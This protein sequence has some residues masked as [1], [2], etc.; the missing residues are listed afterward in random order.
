MKYRSI[1]FL[2]HEETDHDDGLITDEA[3][4]ILHHKSRDPETED[5]SSVLWEMPTA[6]SVQ[7]ALDYLLQWD[8]EPESMEVYDHSPA[9]F[10]D[11][12]ERVERDGRVFEMSYNVGLS[13]IGLCELIEEEENGQG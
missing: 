11:E 8:Y 2:D 13:Y 12:T 4:R 1:V 9:G 5:Y 6:E 7:E 10:R 3:L